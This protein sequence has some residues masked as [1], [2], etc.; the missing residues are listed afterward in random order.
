M[1]FRFNPLLSMTAVGDGIGSCARERYKYLSSLES[2]KSQCFVD[3]EAVVT[4]GDRDRATK[5][6]AS[7]AD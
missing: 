4:Q 5:A 7:Q 1:S 6:W 3:Y 2:R